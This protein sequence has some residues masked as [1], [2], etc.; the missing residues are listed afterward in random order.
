M[1][2][3]WFAFW[4]LYISN[5]LEHVNQK[6]TIIT[7]VPLNKNFLCSNLLHEQKLGLDFF[8]YLKIQ[9]KL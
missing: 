1:L 6:R 8:F 2:D 7:N 5:V 3:F 9:R 4:I